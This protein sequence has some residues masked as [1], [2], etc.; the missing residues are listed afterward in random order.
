MAEVRSPVR[1]SVCCWAGVATSLRRF[2]L[3]IIEIAV[4]AHVVTVTK[5]RL[6]RDN[7]ANASLLVR[8]PYGE[9]SVGLR[10]TLLTPALEELK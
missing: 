7:E 8:R 10:A 3:G 9:L 5:S 4:A 1:Q 2:T 6:P